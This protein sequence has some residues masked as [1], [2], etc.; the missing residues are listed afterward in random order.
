MAPSRKLNVVIGAMGSVVD[1]GKGP[2]RWARWRPTVALCQCEDFLVDELY[3]LTFGTHQSLLKRVVEDIHML[4]PDTVVHETTLTLRDHWD[5]EEVYGALYD[6][7]RSFPFDTERCEYFVHITTGSHV[8]QICLFLLVESRHF[9]G[10]IIQT[11]PPRFSQG[12]TVGRL[13]IIDLD[14]SIYHRLRERFLAESADSQEFLKAGIAT[15]NPPFNQLIAQIERIAL[16]SRAPLL[17]TGPTG[18]GK[19]ELARRI[20]ELKRGRHQLS[21]PLVEVNCATLRGDTAMSTLFGHVRG[22]FTGANHNR[23]GLLRQADG[24]IIFL[25]EIGELGDDEQAMLLR[26]LELRT[27]FPVG[28]DRTV[29]SEFQLIAGTNQDLHLRVV[30]GRFRAD[31]LARIDLWHFHL[32]GLA[33][34]REDIEPNLHYETERCSKILDTRISWNT[35]AW[36]RFLEFSMSDEALWLGNFRDFG[37]AILRLA[38]LAERGRITRDAVRAEIK[39]LVARWEKARS[40]EKKGTDVESVVPAENGVGLDLFD[41]IQ[42]QGVIEVCRRSPSLAA[43]GR[44]LFSESRQR[45]TTGNDT[46]RLRKYLARFGLSWDSVRS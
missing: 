19:S 21:G 8:W 20:Y 37:G 29:E 22:A 18:A 10:K 3:L 35:D 15:R 32:P 9:P 6:F 25:D 5:F 45:K 39:H 17:L 11:S 46:D 33:E 16:R 44:S 23:E 14:L 40:P 26:A 30:Q 41:R 1:A 2:E 34:R 28:S 4:S 13:D 24:G 12:E 36:E 42:L 27:F 38:T 31:L 43:A 7:C